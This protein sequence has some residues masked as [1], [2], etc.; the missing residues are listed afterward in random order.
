MAIASKINYTAD[1]QK[2]RVTISGVQYSRDTKSMFSGSDGIR[3]ITFPAMVRSV[4]QRSFYK[5]RSLRIAI[6]NEGL[7][8][9][10]STSL[11][12][13]DIKCGIFRRTAKTDKVA[14]HGESDW[15]RSVR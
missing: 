4:R 12:S 1:E 7:E 11:L 8:T 6:L 13:A 15:K 14:A 9:L 10:G 5:M 2:M 3:T